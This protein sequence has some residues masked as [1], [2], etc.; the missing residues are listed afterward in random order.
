MSQTNLETRPNPNQDSAPSNNSLIEIT[1]STHNIILDLRYATENNIIGR[2]IVN[3][4][5]C[6]LHP[7]AL[8]LLERSIELAKHQGL[9]LKILDAYRPGYAQE[10]LWAY[11]SNPNYITPPEKGSPHTRGIAVDLTL[12]DASGKELDMGTEFDDLSQN[13]HHVNASVSQQAAANRYT[14]LGIMVSAG[15]DYYPMEWWHY[16]VFN[17]QKYP[18]I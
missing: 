3:E 2:P 18:L 4:Y 5:R 13:S 10:S 6:L 15:W 12:V 1:E 11:C 14:L 17:A 7:D 16:Q 8:A 9:R